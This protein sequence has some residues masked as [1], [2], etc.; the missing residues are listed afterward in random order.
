[1]HARIDD[2]TTA[3]PRASTQCMN[4]ELQK[5]RQ[6]GN[7]L[8]LIRCPCRCTAMTVIDS[9]GKAAD[10]PVLVCYR[11]FLSALFHDLLTAARTT[12]E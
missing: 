6:A 9:I 8:F 2:R 12:Y 3:P 1:M 10:N 7:T 5:A 11:L 4:R